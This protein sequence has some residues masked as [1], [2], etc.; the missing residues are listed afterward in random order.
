MKSIQLNWKRS[1]ATFALLGAVNT[2]L[3]AA[4]AEAQRGADSLHAKIISLK[5]VV[6]SEMAAQLQTSLANK[7][8]RVEADDR[9][10]QLVVLAT[11]KE[12]KE[13]ERAIE[14]TA[15]FALVKSGTHLNAPSGV[16]R[17]DAACRWSGRDD[18][19]AQHMPSTD[20]AASHGAHR[21][22]CECKN[23]GRFVLRRTKRPR[24]L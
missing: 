17:G 15:D 14:M 8:S 18:A 22:R 4:D 13:I 16:T 1:L 23:L 24:S 2:G 3:A 6:P 7:R 20:R 19:R 21:P 5:N 10:G 9:A 11:D 12:L